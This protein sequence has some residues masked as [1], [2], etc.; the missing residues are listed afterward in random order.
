MFRGH[1]SWRE[2][3]ALWVFKT[4]CF[5]NL[6]RICTTLVIEWPPGEPV[7]GPKCLGTVNR[8]GADEN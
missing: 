2:E 5:E 7:L 3:T 4:L 6:L 1:F 8:Q